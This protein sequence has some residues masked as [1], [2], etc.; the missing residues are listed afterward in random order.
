MTDA[1]AARLEVVLRTGGVRAALVHLNGLSGHRFT[2]LYR[3]AGS[4]ARNLYF[5]DRENP[6]VDRGD[7][8]PVEVTYC[9]YVRESGRPFLIEDAPA[10]E[11]VM[12]HGSQHAVRAYCGVPLYDRNGT[13]VGTL[14]HFDTQPVAVPPGTAEVMGHLSRLL[15]T[16]ATGPA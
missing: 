6:G 11:R 2:A 1:P 5:Y 8:Y 16:T 12:G 4:H 3:F 13:V 14:C 15:Q 9:V 10:D 7:D